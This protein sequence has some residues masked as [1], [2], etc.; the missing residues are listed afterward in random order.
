MAA[1]IISPRTQVGVLFALLLLT[2]L[3]VGI[4]FIELAGS[5]HLAWGLGIA[6]VKAS[7][8]VLFFMQ[9]LHS[10]AATRA[11]IIVAVFWLVAVL[12]A[13]TITDYATRE[14]LVVVPG[15]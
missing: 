13:L 10:A 3:T 12:L 14:S 2:A 6:I 8:V 5:W 15:H 9:V 4:S 11:V 7:L 1:H